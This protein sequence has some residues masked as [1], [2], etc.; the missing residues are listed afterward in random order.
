MKM[1][2][3]EKG[4]QRKKRSGGTGW[5]Y[6]GQRGVTTVF[7]T[8]IMV[9]VVVFTS[10]MVDLARWKLYT[11]QAVMAADSYGDAVL[12]E[13]N[14]LLKELY[15]LFAVTQNEEGLNAIKEFADYAGYSFNPNGD[16]AGLS[17]FM[18][19]ANADVVIEYKAAGNSAEPGVPA[20]CS[21]DNPDVLMTQI[22]DFM[23]FRVVQGLVEKITDSIGLLECLSQLSTMGVDTEAVEAREELTECSANIWER[24]RNYYQDLHSLDDYPNY[25]SGRKAAYQDYKE[26]V[27][28]ILNSEGCK[29]YCYYIQNQEE[30]D[31]AKKAL[32]EDDKKKAEAEKKADEE[33]EEKEEKNDAVD[34]TLSAEKRKEL[35]EVAG[36]YVDVRKYREDLKNEIKESQEN[37]GN[38]KMGSK[39]LIDFDTAGDKIKDLRKN[40]E[41]VKKEINDMAEQV[42]KLQGPDGNSGMLAECS[43]E[44]SD[45]IK[46]DIK[47]IGEITKDKD[48]YEEVADWIDTNNFAGTDKNQN[49]KKKMEEYVGEVDQVVNKILEFDKDSKSEDIQKLMDAI[50]EKAE[51]SFEWNNF[52]TPEDC[53]EYSKYHEFYEKLKGLWENA[54]GKEVKAKKTKQEG[55]AE[56]GLDDAKAAMEELEK[57]EEELQVRNISDEL[58]AAVWGPAGERESG[59]EKEFSFAKAFSGDGISALKDVPTRVLSKFILSSYDFGMFSSRVSGIEPPEKESSDASEGADSLKD[60]D[61]N[62]SLEGNSTLEET[63]PKKNLLEKT[64][65]GT[66]SDAAEDGKVSEETNT[67]EDSTEEGGGEGTGSSEEYA[68]YSLTKVKMSEDVNYL[69]GAELEYIYAGKKNSKDNLNAA[70]NSVLAIRTTMNFMSTFTIKQ[71]H[72]SIES[73]A[74]EASVAAAAAGGPSAP[75]VKVLVHVSVSGILR[76]AFALIES[77]ADWQKLVKREGVILVKRRLEELSALDL[78]KSLLPS[79]ETVSEG[80]GLPKTDEG[81]KEGGEK[82]DDKPVADITPKD[83]NTPGNT[84]AGGTSSQASELLDK[85]MPSPTYED[86][87]S[88]LLFCF[89]NLD[90]MLYRTSDL[91]T[92]NVNQAEQGAEELQTPLSFTMRDTVTAVKS[93]CKVKA[94]FTVLPDNFAKMFLEGSTVEDGIATIEDEYFGYSVIRGY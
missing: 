33:G 25:L 73:I 35:E 38:N 51:L 36:K 13:Y 19:Y 75:L 27:K 56:K 90:D 74:N 53:Q 85:V 45:G 17:G 28:K 32:E 59:G 82:T 9:P 94:Q 18:P 42:E 60:V 50:E 2:K 67:E 58:A 64:K 72:N 86:Y 46:E 8:L 89:T 55:E 62:D 65:S 77:S 79:L 37:A 3:S 10:L 44:V 30:I 1:K 26:N 66:D 71:V 81:S 12:S 84:P 76:S 7:V 15:G 39:Y 63:E 49:N 54:D 92:L 69:Y 22:N 41:K 83:G 5:R 20:E 34:T 48:T 11:S 21:L 93:T 4:R 88:I 14:N 87:L 23:E 80:D 91:I 57:Q 70:R 16:D 24:M 52:N 6:R 40:A 68:D 29:N 61:D 31:S 47:D 43:Q 78:L